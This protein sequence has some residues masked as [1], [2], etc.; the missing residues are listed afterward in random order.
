VQVQDGQITA[1][2]PRDPFV[3]LFPTA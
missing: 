2:T 1:Y 3:P